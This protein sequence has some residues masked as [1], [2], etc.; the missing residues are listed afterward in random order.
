MIRQT[1]AVTVAGLFG[2]ALYAASKPI[3]VEMKDAKGQS[4]GTAVISERKQ[5]GVAIKAEF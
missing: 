5:G 2:C 3:T 1:V 4:V